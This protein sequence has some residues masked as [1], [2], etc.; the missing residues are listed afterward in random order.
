LQNTTWPE[1]SGVAPEVTVAVKVT[2]EPAVTFAGD[3]ASVVVVLAAV[4]AR[5]GAERTRTL[6]I[7]MAGS[8]AKS[9]R[10]RMTFLF[11]MTLW[12][13]A[14]LQIP[15]MISL[16]EGVG[17]AQSRLLVSIYEQAFTNNEGDSSHSQACL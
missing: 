11:A 10:L 17:C 15:R 4:T 3:T 6:A 14:M 9:E 2:T 12:I 5:A 7:N 16:D 8:S 1:V 13:K